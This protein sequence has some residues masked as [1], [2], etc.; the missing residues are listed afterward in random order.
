MQ[1]KS[2]HITT[3]QQSTWGRVYVCFEKD[4]QSFY[5]FKNFIEFKELN[6]IGDGNI[7][8]EP[9]FTWFEQNKR[10]SFSL[11]EVLSGNADHLF[12]TPDKWKTLYGSPSILL[13]RLLIDIYSNNLTPVDHR[14]GWFNHFYLPTLHSSDLHIT[15]G[16]NQLVLV[17]YHEKL[18]LEPLMKTLY[19]LHLKHPEGIIRKQI[20]LYEKEMEEIYMQITNKSDLEKVKSSLKTLVDLESKSFDEK[21]SKIKKTLIDLLGDKL[22]YNY[23]ISKSETDDYKIKL[24]QDK[25]FFD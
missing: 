14:R 9:A 4:N 15:K 24:S 23:I 25:I 18:I 10:F 16:Y 2:I 17:D 8:N 3:Y 13:K 19:I 1:I 21:V 6:Y 12:L 5:A 11:E 22:A 20:G 7:E